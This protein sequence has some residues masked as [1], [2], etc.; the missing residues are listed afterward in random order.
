MVRSNIFIEVF[1]TTFLLIDRNFM[2][3]QILLNLLQNWL[4]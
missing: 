2:H 4:R 3:F 1:L